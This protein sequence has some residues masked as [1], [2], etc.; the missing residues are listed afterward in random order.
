MPPDDQPTPTDETG[1]TLVRTT[2]N[3]DRELWVDDSERLDLER[4]GLLVDSAIPRPEDEGAA[5]ARPRKTA[6]PKAD[7]DT[8][9]EG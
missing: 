4:A 6:Q 3:P 1:R 8:S 2:I 7:G 9:G 5:P